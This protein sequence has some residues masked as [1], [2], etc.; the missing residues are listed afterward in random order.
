[1]SNKISVIDSSALLAI[2]YDEG[3]N[4]EV[5]KHFDHSYMSVIMVWPLAP[6]PQGTRAPGHQ[7]P[8]PQGTRLQAAAGRS[9]PQAPDL[10]PQ[11]PG[12]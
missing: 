2:I 4:K 3:E 10:R 9:R 1:M 11:A 5:Q 7:G 6:G 12:P 8:R